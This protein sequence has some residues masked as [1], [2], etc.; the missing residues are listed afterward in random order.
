MLQGNK[1]FEKSTYI[2]RAGVVP[3][4]MD[5]EDADVAAVVVLHEQG[6]IEALVE[7][8]WSTVPPLAHGSDCVCVVKAECAVAPPGS[9]DPV[10]TAEQTG[11]TEDARVSTW[12]QAVFG[13]RTHTH[14]TS[15][16]EVPE[17]PAD[18][19]GQANECTHNG[20]RYES[21]RRFR[22]LGSSRFCIGCGKS[23]YR[24]SDDGATQCDDLDR[25]HR[26]GGRRWAHRRRRRRG[27]W[28]GNGGCLLRSLKRKV[29]KSGTD[30]NCA[31]RAKE[32]DGHTAVTREIIA[33]NDLVTVWRTVR[34]L[35]SAL[36]VEDETG[37][38]EGLC[39]KLVKLEIFSDEVDDSAL[40]ERDIDFE[41]IVTACKLVGT[42]KETIAGGGEDWVHGNGRVLD[43]DADRSA[44]G[45]NSKVAGAKL[46]VEVGILTAVVSG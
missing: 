39:T 10:W 7:D 6:R 42:T 15:T 45:G 26:C 8:E 1:E 35:V 44:A 17:N 2:E 36:T 16:T 13:V 3:V 46:T 41:D 40:K 25:S 9:V 38:V 32:I 5:S 43:G 22:T 21:T 34:V 11:A 33:D 12:I 30:E 37:G 29:S 19:A 28:F 24:L 18:N 4:V 27:G 23:G 20:S 14:L 31:P